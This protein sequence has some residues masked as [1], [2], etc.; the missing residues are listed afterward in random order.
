MLMLSKVANLCERIQAG[1]AMKPVPQNARK[2]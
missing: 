1:H 2:K